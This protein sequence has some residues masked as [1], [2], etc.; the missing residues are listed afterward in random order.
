MLDRRSFLSVSTAFSIGSLTSVSGSDEQSVHAASNPALGKVVDV[1]VHIGTVPAGKSDPLTAEDLLR[2]MDARGVSQAW[3][4]PL[5]SPEA[6]ADPVPTRYVL[7]AT[8][9][10]RDRM[11][12]FCVIDPRNS[13]YVRGK[14][15]VLQ[16][17]LQAYM[18]A[19]AK[20]FG[21]HKPGIPIDDPRNMELYAACAEKKLPVLF[22]LDAKRNMDVPGLPGLERVLKAF[23]ELPFIGHAHGFWA[24][25]SGNVTAVEL[26]KYP[27]SKIA[28]GGALDRLF[29]QYPNLYGDVSSGSGMNA[30]TRDPDFTIPFL[31]RRADRLLFG[32]DYLTHGWDTGQHDLFRRLNLPP[33]VTNRIL[34]QNARKLIG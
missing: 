11:I 31:T 34:H 28:P 22:H 19:G 12:P 25:I 26:G 29:D 21:E 3:V 30:L 17:Q 33:D 23:P 15:D 20:G 1:H 6:F 8:K 18:D 16:A 14:A 10:Y 4:L 5:V 2:E 24:S 7:A 27:K 13:W 9:P 32:T